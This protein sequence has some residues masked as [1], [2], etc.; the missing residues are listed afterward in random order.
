A[1]LTR[2]A[3]IFLRHTSSKSVLSIGLATS[4]AIAAAASMVSSLRSRS[5]SD[6][7]ARSAAS[8]LDDTAPST[9]RASTTRGPSSLAATA[10]DA[11]GKPNE[12]GRRSFQDR[13]RHPA[14]RGGVTPVRV[15]SGG[16]G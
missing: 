1:F 10:A 8:G 4:L 16:R 2:D 6:C 12:P 13:Q 11:T 14:A 5:V 15:L 3:I 7:A 9:I